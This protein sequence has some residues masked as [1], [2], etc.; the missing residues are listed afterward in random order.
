[1]FRYSRRPYYINRYLLYRHVVY[2]NFLAYFF[3]DSSI[4]VITIDDLGEKQNVHAI[5][6]NRCFSVRYK[7]TKGL[8]I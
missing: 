5:V 3:M 2:I 6:V 7:K 4:M 8:F 1:M